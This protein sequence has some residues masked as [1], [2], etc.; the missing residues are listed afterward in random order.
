MT[1]TATRRS[2]SSNVAWLF[3][4]I[5][6]G[7]CEL[8]PTPTTAGPLEGY[9]END[10]CSVSVSGNRLFF[11]GRDDFWF[12]T[13]FILPPGTDPKQLRATI[14]NDGSDDADNIGKVVNAI[15]KIEGRT[16]TLVALPEGATT[17]SSVI[18]SFDFIHFSRSGSVLGCFLIT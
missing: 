6:I 9:W 2:A 13:E 10:D 12:H 18:A 3:V 14:L 8:E 7:A 11:F 1:N 17:G 5:L 15:Y 4:A 16:L